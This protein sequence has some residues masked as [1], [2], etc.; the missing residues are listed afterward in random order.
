MMK[1]RLPLFAALPATAVLLAGCGLFHS[2]FSV[3]VGNRTANMVTVF[4]NGESIG[5]VGSNQ[6]AT[7]TLE[8]SSTGKTTVDSLGNPTSP[9]PTAQ[10]TFSARD[11]ATSI[12]SAGAAATLIHDVTAYVDVAPCALIDGASTGL[13]CVSVAN[14]SS[15]RSQA[16][17][18]SLSPSSQSFDGAGGT[19]TASVEASSGCSWSATSNASWIRLVSGGSGTGNG[20]VV[21]EVQ[22]NTTGQ[23][24]TGSL[25]IA[26]QTFTV[27]QAPSLSVFDSVESRAGSAGSRAKVR[28]CAE[29]A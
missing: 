13:I 3:A 26:G 6:T 7:F 11:M 22:A 25:S 20:V 16:C 12:L 23:A 27:N 29:I 8:L 4:A 1:T 5:E 28:A 21:F 19:G 15:G 17:S 9:T 24:R 18:F 2:D 10:V 14:T